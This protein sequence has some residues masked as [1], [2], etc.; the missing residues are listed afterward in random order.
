MGTLVARSLVAQL[1]SAPTVKFWSDDGA[2]PLSPNLVRIFENINK[3]VYKILTTK[4]VYGTKIEKYI[5]LRIINSLLPHTR[6]TT[7]N[8]HCKLKYKKYLFRLNLTKF[9]LDTLTIIYRYNVL[10]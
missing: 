7:K 2:V 5:S 8:K 1:S 6:L 3:E 4:R 10:A 9:P